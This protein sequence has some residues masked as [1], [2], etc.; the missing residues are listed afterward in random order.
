MFA[1]KNILVPIDFSGNSDKVLQNALDIAKK[2]SSNIFLL[3]VVNIIQQC[4]TTYCI[5]MTSMIQLENDSV[6]KSKETL[7]NMVDKSPD[8]K[9]L[10]I[11]INVLKGNTSEKILEAQQ[12][13][14]IDLVVMG[15]HGRKGIF[16]SLLGSVTDRISHHVKCSILIVKD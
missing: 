14:K 4:S 11:V 6:K 3:H 8:S 5:D 10:K 2:F 1:P 15:S 13:N 16:G 9:G 7:Q 12:E